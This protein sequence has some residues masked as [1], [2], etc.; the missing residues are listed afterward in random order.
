M[1]RHALLYTPSKSDLGARIHF[2]EWYDFFVLVP[3]LT[4]EPTIY[5]VL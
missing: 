1:E 5:T 3:V 2:D 4:R